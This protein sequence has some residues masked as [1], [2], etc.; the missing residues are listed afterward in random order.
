LSNASTELKIQSFYK[1]IITVFQ[2]TQ[3]AT[4]IVPCAM[5]GTHA[6]GCRC[7]TEQLEN[8]I[9]LSRIHWHVIFRYEKKNFQKIFHTSIS[10]YKSQS[11]KNTVTG[12]F[13]A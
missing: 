10:E 7:L 13:A 8:K 6:V 5:L 3:R 2:F 11:V 1:I 4:E 12:S 9:K